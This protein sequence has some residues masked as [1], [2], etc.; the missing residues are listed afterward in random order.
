MARDVKYITLY[1]FRHM[2][3]YSFATPIWVQSRPII[4]NTWPN[5]SDLVIVPSMS[6][7]TTWSFASHRNM[8]AVHAMAP[9]ADNENVIGFGPAFKS[10]CFCLVVRTRSLQTKV[11]KR[12]PTDRKSDGGFSHIASPFHQLLPPKIEL[13]FEKATALPRM[14]SPR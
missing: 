9:D 6:E 12:S 10:S 13:S 14:F 1:P 3:V 2:S 8:R 7:T 11:Y 4:V 5:A